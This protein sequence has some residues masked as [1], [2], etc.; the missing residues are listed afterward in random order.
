MT[1]PN[2]C[3]RVCTL[4]WRHAWCIAQFIIQLWLAPRFAM[5]MQRA[6][7]VWISLLSVALS[8]EYFVFCQIVCD[9]VLRAIFAHI[10]CLIVWSPNKNPSLQAPSR[11]W[12]L[13]CEIHYWSLLIYLLPV[14][15][16]SICHQYNVLGTRFLRVLIMHECMWHDIRVHMTYI[17]THTSAYPGSR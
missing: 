11:V 1:A 4:F 7:W 13:M 3:D 15:G 16:R 6:P 5:C 8:V 10:K 2:V 12:C 9:C 17:H 14:P